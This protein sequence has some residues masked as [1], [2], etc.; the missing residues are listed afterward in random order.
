[1]SAEINVYRGRKITAE[2]KSHGGTAWV[3]LMF[4]TTERTDDFRV[5]MFFE[6]P[7]NAE[8]AQSYARAINAASS[9]PV[10]A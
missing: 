3:E 10:P 8:V 7:D 9:V 6:G 5:S 4:A 1:M 2:A